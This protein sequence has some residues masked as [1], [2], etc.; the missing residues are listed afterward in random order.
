MEPI[1]ITEQ[2]DPNWGRVVKLTNGIIELRVTL[3]FGPRII[4]LSKVGFE[5]MMYEDFSKST[6]GD[7]YDVYEDHLKLYGGH[8]LWLSP[9]IVPR[10]YYPDSYPVSWEKLP[11][12]AV[13]TAPEEKINNIQKS[14]HIQLHE[15]QPYASLE[16]KVKNC[17]AWDIEFS[18]WCITML[19]KGGKE[20][21][22]MPNLKTGLLPNRNIS[23]WDYSDM[24]DERVYWGKDYITLIQDPAKSNPF[25]LGI[26]NEHGWAAYF[27]RGQIFIKNF[28]SYLDGYYPDNGCSFE[29]YTNGQ[30]LEC[31]SLGEIKGL[32]P[33]EEASVTEEWEIFEA[34]SPPSNNEDEISEIM[35]KYL[36]L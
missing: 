1:S 6:L 18:H 23:L 3:D 31:E 24:N 22:P 5:N 7:K 32:E 29:T 2:T 4:H 35:S 8:R 36:N 16:H 28:D 9:E 26:N 10:C 34:P 14:I 15:G 11:D 17:G 21:I 20:I 27:N 19:A 25:K 33:S 13:F 30:M 12:G